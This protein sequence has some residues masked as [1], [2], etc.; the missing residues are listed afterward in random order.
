MRISSLIITFCCFL[1]F[2]L[3]SALLVYMQMGAVKNLQFSMLEDK[4][5]AET[6]QI[7]SWSMKSMDE[8]KITETPLPV[9]WGEIMIVDNTSLVIK[10]STNLE[11]TGMLLHSIPQLLDEASTLIDAIKKPGEKTF[12]TDKYM[13]AVSPISR[14][15]TL[16]GFKPRSWEQELISQQTDHV[17]RSAESFRT[18]VIAYLAVGTVLAFAFPLLIAMVTSAPLKRAANAFERLS[19]GDFDAELP[20]SGGK[21]M[22][23]LSESFFRLKTSLKIALDKLGSR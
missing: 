13:I 6:T 16:I 11:H 17:R 8:G 23:I 18:I 21:S 7:L 19:L 22:A 3:G 2:L 12:Q 1:V 9:S 5:Y 15:R 14:N 4:L 20:P 10:S